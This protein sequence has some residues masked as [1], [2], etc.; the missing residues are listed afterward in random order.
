MF[1]FYCT[2]IWARCGQK[3]ISY[4]EFSSTF[5]KLEKVI[6]KELIK[7]LFMLFVVPGCY[8]LVWEPFSAMWVCTILCFVKLY[9]NNIIDFNYNF[10]IVIRW[11]L[12]GET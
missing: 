3:E 8:T 1:G 9:D 5:N 7:S 6:N 4:M 10:N 11:D 2:A 12:K